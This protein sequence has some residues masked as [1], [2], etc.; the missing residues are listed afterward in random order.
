MIVN[1]GVEGWYYVYHA[2]F[3]NQTNKHPHHQGRGKVGI[4]KRLKKRLAEQRLVIGQNCE[5]IC[6]V[7]QKLPAQL[8]GDIERLIAKHYGYDVGNPY[9]EKR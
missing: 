9:D 4:T 2:P 1:I 7:S 8:A 3:G 6:A 5:I